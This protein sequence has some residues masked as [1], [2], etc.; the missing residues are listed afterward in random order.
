MNSRKDLFKEQRNLLDSS[1]PPKS[2]FTIELEER[3][4]LMF[5]KTY[6][7][8]F[9]DWYELYYL[10]DGSC[11]YHLDKK[12]YLVNKGDWIFIPPKA[13]H[14][15]LYHSG[16]HQRCLIY[17]SKDYIPPEILPHIDTLIADPIFSPSPAMAGELDSAGFLAQKILAE[18]KN[19]TEFST[20]LIKCYLLEL[21]VLFL[22]ISTFTMQKT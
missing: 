7:F 13:P 12:S 21:F 16:S 8:H 18:F 4:D 20:A 3:D 9:H 17:F 14:K 10:Q 5:N 1:N 19:S 11:T 22:I 2:L 6:P 15:V